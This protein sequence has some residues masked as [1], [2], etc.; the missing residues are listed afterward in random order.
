MP[1]YMTTR[2]DLKKTMS[3]RAW[4]EANKVAYYHVGMMFE[5]EIKPTKFSASA[6]ATYDYQP[7]KPKY[8]ARKRGG[9]VRSLAGGKYPIPEGGTR[10]L[11]YSGRLRAA[12]LKPHFPRVFPTRVTIRYNTPRSP[13]GHDYANMRPFKSGHPNIGEELTRVTPEQFRRMESIYHD[14]MEAAV[15]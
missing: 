1:F 2:D 3:D 4:R 10:D 9:Y 15:Q 14:Q 11:V 13:Q 7:R 8:L 5:Q 6:A 12:V